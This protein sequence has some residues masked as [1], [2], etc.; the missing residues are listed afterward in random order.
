MGVRGRWPTAP[1]IARKVPLLFSWFVSPGT[2]ST[3]TSIFEATPSGTPA[4]GDFHV[5]PC[6]PGSVVLIACEAL[7]CLPPAVTVTS[8]LTFVSGISPAFSTVTVNV[9]LPPPLMWFSVGSGSSVFVPTLTP[10]SALPWVP[11]DDRPLWEEL[12]AWPVRRASTVAG[13]S[14]PRFGRKRLGARAQAR[15]CRSRRA[16]A[17]SAARRAGSRSR[18]RPGRSPCRRRSACSPA[19]PGRRARCGTSAAILVSPS[20]RRSSASS[21]SRWAPAISPGT[22]R[23]LAR[24]ASFCACD[25]QLVDLHL[26]VERRLAGGVGRAPTN[27]GCGDLFV[28]FLGDPADVAVV[29]LQRLLSSGFSGSR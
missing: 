28:G 7:N 21:R 26:H 1:K 24:V 23:P 10:I 27:S 22:L 11:G 8:T 9:G 18:R 2:G 4:D 20:T 19:W 25:A 17:G 15:E 13:S 29:V 3:W 6:L 16:S 5:R 12:A 14:Q